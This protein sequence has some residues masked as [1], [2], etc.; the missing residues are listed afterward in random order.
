MDRQRGVGR[1]DGRRREGQ[2]DRAFCARGHGDSRAGVIGDGEGPCVLA[3]EPQARHV[4]NA[5]AR[6]ADGHHLSL[7]GLAIRRVRESE[8]RCR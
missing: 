7:A 5:V 3:A 4:K 6:V 1:P 8:A 2:R